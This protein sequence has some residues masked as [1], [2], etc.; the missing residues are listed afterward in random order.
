MEQF[1]EI[2]VS[3]TFETNKRSGVYVIYYSE[4]E[5]KTVEEFVQLAI[6]EIKKQ[7]ES[8]TN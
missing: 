4:H 2:T 7:I 1:R 5:E 3:V 8:I 6:E